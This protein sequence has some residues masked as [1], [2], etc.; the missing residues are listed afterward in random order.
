MLTNIKRI[1]KSFKKQG[2][3]WVE[4]ETDTI[5]IDE[6]FYNNMTDPICARFMR[7]IGGYERAYKGYTEYGYRVNRIVSISPDRT[8]KREYIFKFKGCKNV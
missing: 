3:K 5:Y 6:K 2:S 8:E 7:S 4:Y 1:S